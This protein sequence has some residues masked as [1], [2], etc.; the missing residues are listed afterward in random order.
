M[1]YPCFIIW[2]PANNILIDTAISTYEASIRLEKNL[3]LTAR[4]VTFQRRADYIASV[5]TSHGGL[6]SQSM[7][8]QYKQACQ[9]RDAGLLT[10]VIAQMWRHAWGFNLV[11]KPYEIRCVDIDILVPNESILEVIEKV[12]D[13]RSIV[14]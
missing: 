12:D 5:L 3:E 13:T 4:Y 1:K 11:P 6:D 10:H 14:I 9:M 2:D 7:V 8:A